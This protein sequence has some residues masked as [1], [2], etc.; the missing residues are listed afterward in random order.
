GNVDTRLRKVAEAHDGLDAAVLAMAGLTRLDLS[1][2]ISEPL[3]VDLCLPA[4]G[5]G[6]LGIQIRDDDPPPRHPPAPLPPP[7]TPTSHHPQT[8]ACV[9]AERALLSLLSGSCHLP[10]AAFATLHGDA[11]TL[12]A[13]LGSPD[14]AQII[15]HTAAGPASDPHALAQTVSDALFA[16]GARDL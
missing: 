4:V 10:I 3:D 7:P 13:R 8:A 1:D 16:D 6:A 11:L 14:G 9:N 5:Q 12:R 2:H 15:E